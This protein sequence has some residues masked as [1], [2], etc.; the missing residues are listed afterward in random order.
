MKKN[1]NPERTKTLK[2]K[3]KIPF[4]YRFCLGGASFF[5]ARMSLFTG[6]AFSF[7]GTIDL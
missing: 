6:V 7:R 1:R 5:L 3:G 2:E 4:R